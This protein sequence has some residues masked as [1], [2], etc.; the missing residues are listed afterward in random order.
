MIALAWRTVAVAMGLV[1]VR[2]LAATAL[3]VTG[4]PAPLGAVMA[5]ALL[6]AFVLVGVAVPLH[7]S[8]RERAIPLFLLAL[9]IESSAL[10]AARRRRRAAGGRAHGG[11]ARCIG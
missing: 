1:V 9:G 8:R 6:T 7:G 5:N 4:V 3:G 2:G 10:A 11:R